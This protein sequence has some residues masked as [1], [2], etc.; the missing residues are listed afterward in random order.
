M[1]RTASN[2]EQTNILSVHKLDADV[3]YGSSKEYLVANMI[4]GRC[5]PEVHVCHLAVR[6]N[7]PQEARTPQSITLTVARDGLSRCENNIRPAGQVAA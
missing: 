7:A 1:F 6:R 4:C 5:G 2:F 3:A